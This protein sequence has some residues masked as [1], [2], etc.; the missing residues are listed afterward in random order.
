MNCDTGHIRNYSFNENPPHGYEPLPDSLVPAARKVMGDRDEGKVSLT[1]G[2]KLS[3]WAAKQRK[4]RK[5]MQKDSRRR[6]R[7]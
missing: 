2:G 6:N 5:R 1:S 4:A 3:K 7:N